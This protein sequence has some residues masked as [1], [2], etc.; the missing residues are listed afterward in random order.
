MALERILYCT[1]IPSTPCTRLLN[2]SNIHFINHF[3]KVASS[4]HNC[5]LITQSAC[6]NIYIYLYITRLTISFV[7]TYSPKTKVMR[8]SIFVLSVFVV[9]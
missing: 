3:V 8:L 2:V 5:R 7:G 6:T 9:M 1:T 4:M